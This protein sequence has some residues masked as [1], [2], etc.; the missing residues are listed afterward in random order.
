ME[1]SSR[2]IVKEKISEK[3][4]IFYSKWKDA[5]NISDNG[6]LKVRVLGD[7][8]SGKERKLFN[9]GIFVTFEFCIMRM[10]YKFKNLEKK[11]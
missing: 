4:Y 7:W 6:S 5:Q 3:T 2:F 8:G 1:H 10:C 11:F 9:T